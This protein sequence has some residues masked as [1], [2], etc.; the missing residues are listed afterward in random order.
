MSELAIGGR[1]AAMPGYVQLQRH[2]WKS[3]GSVC[4]VDTTATS[5][6]SCPGDGSRI[7]DNWSL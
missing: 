2:T 1:Y 6:A 7:G 3:R 4:F 5:T